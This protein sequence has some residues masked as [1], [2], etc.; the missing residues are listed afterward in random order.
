MESYTFNC[1]VYDQIKVGSLT[2]KTGN[3]IVDMSVSVKIF[4]LNDFNGYIIIIKSISTLSIDHF[5][6]VYVSCLVD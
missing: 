4:N 6:S 3:L 1:H 2:V 5:T